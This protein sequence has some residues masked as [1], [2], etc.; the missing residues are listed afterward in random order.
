[1][2][3]EAA[4]KIQITFYVFSYFGKL[5]CKISFINIIYREGINTEF[6]CLC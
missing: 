5:V 2:S 1:M 4:N 3:L 6:V